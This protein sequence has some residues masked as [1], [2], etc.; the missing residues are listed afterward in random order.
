MEPTERVEE[1][2]LRFRPMRVEDIETICEI[3]KESFTT[4][5]TAGAFHNELTNNHFAHYIVMEL[6]GEIVGYG[7]M[8]LIMDEAHVTN[9][10]VRSA[11]RGRKLGERLMIRI[12]SAAVFLGAERITLEVRTSNI[13]AQRLYAKLGF[14]P[15]GL[16]KG[17]YTDNGEDAII[18]WAHLG[19]LSE[20]G[21]R[22]RE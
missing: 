10:A 16:R 17:Y 12:Q 21:A 19:R 18:M 13:V 1:D 22:E 9:V 15:A 6:D 3:E 7:G 5:W 14:I 8:W 20:E 11:Y 2:G 4:P